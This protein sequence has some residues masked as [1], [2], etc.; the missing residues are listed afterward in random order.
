MTNTF[1]AMRSSLEDSSVGEV[2]LR[3]LRTRRLVIPNKGGEGRIY[4]LCR[5]QLGARVV[6]Q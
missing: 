4:R 5:S 1:E 6:M 2:D 3:R